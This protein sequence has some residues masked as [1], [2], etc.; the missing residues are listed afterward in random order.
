MATGRLLLM[1]TPPPP[2]YETA[3]M[4]M[5]TMLMAMHDGGNDKASGDNYSG[6]EMTTYTNMTMMIDD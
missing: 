6:N 3:I 5:L 2:A 4:S 1:A